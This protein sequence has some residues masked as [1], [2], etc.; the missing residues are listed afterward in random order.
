MYKLVA[1]HGLEG[2]QTWRSALATRSIAVASSLS[3]FL[4]GVMLI[5]LGSLAAFVVGAPRD[6][7]VKLVTAPP[8]PFI[9]PNAS[10]RVKSID[11]ASKTPPT[12]TLV[13]RQSGESAPPFQKTTAPPAEAPDA[14]LPAPLPT[15]KSAGPQ[16]DP[17]TPL[18]EPDAWSS[19]EVLAARQDCA[20]QL[21]PI[22]ATLEIMPP[23]KLGQCGTP[24]P[25]SMRAIGL[26][27]VALQ[28]PV[29]TT[30]RMVVALH[31]WIDSAVQPAAKDVF[32]SP[33]L[34][35]IGGPTYACRNRNNEAD[36][37]ISEHAFANAIDISAFVLENGRTITVLKGWGATVRDRNSGTGT[38]APKKGVPSGQPVSPDCAA[39]AASSGP[40]ATTAPAASTP[41][42]ASP[43]ATDEC[44]FLHRLH[45]AACG[46]FSTV[47]GPEANEFHRNHF[48]FD[49]KARKSRAFCE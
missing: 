22:S 30:C 19:A 16:P 26:S 39:S 2:A 41:S 17:P 42:A 24:A 29:I 27:K 38:G 32:G 35:I 7:D 1:T 3:T 18:P 14:P 9:A 25:V 4:S 12:K 10:Q 11:V 15:Q 37:P 47:L 44:R 28:P 45:Q 49:L 8:Q 21:A 36:G 40:P 23:I 31:Q 20:Q 43:V 46:I 33:V 34:R 6:S 13:E 5:G 48:H